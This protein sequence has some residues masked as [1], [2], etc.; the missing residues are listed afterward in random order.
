MATDAL[1]RLGP[2]PIDLSRKG[3]SRVLQGNGLVLKIGPWDRTAREA[4]LL[5][6][7]NLPLQTPPLVDSGD[8][9]LLLRSVEDVEASDV[10]LSD[11]A[12]LHDAFAGAP[13]LEDERLR[14]VTGRELPTLLERAAD[15]K[16]PEPFRSLIADPSSVLAEL[17]SP[18]TLVHGDA[19]PGNVLGTYWIDWEEAGSGHPA[20]DLA[21]WLYGSPWVPASSDPARDLTIY[22]D[23]RADRIDADGFARAVDAA[24]VLLFMLL[25]LPGIAGWDEKA[26][27]EVVTRRAA[28]ARRLLGHADE[29]D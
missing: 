26:R 1:A 29:A 12:R 17:S 6:E 27:Q 15:F 22:L 25:D 16:P 20:L 7:L 2:S 3:S 9:W 19:W 4:F 14:G 11:L 8:G 28:T 21:N 24:V 23:A 10:A 18:D 5:G 13:E